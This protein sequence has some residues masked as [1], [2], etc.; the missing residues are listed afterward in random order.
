MNVLFG[1]ISWMVYYAYISTIKMHVMVNYKF[2][3]QNKFLVGH[4]QLGHPGSVMM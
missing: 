1:M 4:D 2:T 3:N